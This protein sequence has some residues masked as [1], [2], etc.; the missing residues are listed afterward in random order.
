[1]RSS[2][3]FLAFSAAS[4][5]SVAGSIPAPDGDIYGLAYGAGSLWA[6]DEVSN[7]IY[8]IDPATG[9]V[10]SSWHIEPVYGSTLT[11]CGFGGNTVYVS[12]D[13]I[14][15]FEYTPEGIYSGNFSASC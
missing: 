10:Q 15:V 12:M 2:V 3:L 6:V 7:F 9:D 1:M 11:G 13:E 8:R 4:A 14:W 5:G